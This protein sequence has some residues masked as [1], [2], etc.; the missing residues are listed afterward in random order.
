VLAI[1]LG[2][3]ASERLLLAR[4]LQSCFVGRPSTEDQIRR[5]ACKLEPRDADPYGGGGS[6]RVDTVSL[7][8]V[9]W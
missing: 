4:V 7:S 9:S 1:M 6:C 8:G 3:C 2:D 5:R